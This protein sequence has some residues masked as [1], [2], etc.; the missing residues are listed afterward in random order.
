MAGLPSDEAAPQY[1]CARARCQTAGAA[2]DQGRRI[3]DPP[4][5]AYNLLAY[6]WNDKG[7]VAE[8]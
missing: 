5:L 7:S 4:Y 2:P 1:N 3:V 8:L 6:L